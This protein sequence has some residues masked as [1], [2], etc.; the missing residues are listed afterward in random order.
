MKI[1]RKGLSSAARKCI[2]R[3]RDDGS[4]LLSG[5]TDYP[6]Y[7]AF[8]V[9]TEVEGGSTGLSRVGLTNSTVTL[10][11]GSDDPYWNYVR[12]RVWEVKKPT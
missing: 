11:R 10:Y 12:V 5:E 4:F 6:N 9:E 2:M 3:A 1:V 7:E 8:L